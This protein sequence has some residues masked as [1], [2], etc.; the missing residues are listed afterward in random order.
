MLKEN[1]REA[2]QEPTAATHKTGVNWVANIIGEIIAKEVLIYVTQS[3]QAE[4]S[5]IKQYG[6]FGKPFLSNR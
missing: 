1:L 4:R 6:L 3:W 5:H 2:W